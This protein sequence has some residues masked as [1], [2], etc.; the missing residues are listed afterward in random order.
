MNKKSNNSQCPHAEDLMSVIMDNEGSSADQERIQMHVRVCPTCS[1]L[2]QEFKMT[3]D[4]MAVRGHHAVRLSPVFTASV[5]DEVSGYADGGIFEDI[6]GLSRKLVS[7]IA[8]VVFILLG[9]MYFPRAIDIDTLLIDELTIINGIE[10]EVLVK[11]E[12]THDD[13]VSLLLTM[14]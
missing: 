5:M 11:D 13:V 4:L 1:S 2:L 8:M 9:I 7:S 14:R 3:K 6:I 10:S 12:F